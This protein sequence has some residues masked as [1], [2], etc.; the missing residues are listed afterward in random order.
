MVTNEHQI[1][2]IYD[3]LKEHISKL[4]STLN[5]EKQSSILHALAIKKKKFS[6]TEEKLFKLVVE[7]TFVKTRNNINRSFIGTLISLNLDTAI[8][9]NSPNLKYIIK[10]TSHTEFKRIWLIEQVLKKLTRSK[11][12]SKP[13]NDHMHPNILLLHITN[14]QEYLHWPYTTTS[15]NYLHNSTWC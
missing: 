8:A 2:I 15:P 11:P 6:S 14:Y 7:H 12:T 13:T 5:L 10:T 3:F 9:Q 1:K 4:D